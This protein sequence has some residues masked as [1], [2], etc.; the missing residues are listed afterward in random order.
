MPILKSYESHSSGSQLLDETSFQ[1]AS[2]SANRGRLTGR[3]HTHHDGGSHVSTE[4]I[5]CAA[6]ADMTG[7]L[8]FT[9]TATA[10][11]G[12]IVSTSRNL[13]TLTGRVWRQTNAQ[14]VA[15]VYTY[16]GLG[17]MVKRTIAPGTAYV[18]MLTLDPVITGASSEAFQVTSTDVNGNKIRKGMDGTGRLLY[19]APNDIDNAI[20][21]P[22]SSLYQTS[23]R[24]YDALGR[25]ATL[26]SRDWLLE[27]SEQYSRTGTLGYDDWGQP[28][29]MDYDDGSWRSSVHDP[30]ALS[31]TATMGGTNKSGSVTSGLTVTTHDVSGKPVRVAR[32]AKNADP[33]SATPYS[34]HTLSYDGLHRLRSQTDALTHT[35]TYEYDAW[36]RLVSSTLADLTV[37]TR[38][39]RADSASADIVEITVT[40]TKLGLAKTSMGTRAFDGLGR[41]SAAHIGGRAWQYDYARPDRSTQLM[42]PHPTQITAP[43]GTV[44]QYDY[45]PELGNKVKQVRGYA[46]A[47]A[48]LARNPSITQTFGYDVSTGQMTSA[49]EGAASGKYETYNSG[50]LKT[51]TL[52]RDGKT[53]TM[54]YQ[55]YSLR[56]KLHQY[57]HVDSAVRLLKRDTGGRV[58]EVGD[59]AMKVSLNYDPAGRLTSWTAQDLKGGTAALTTTLQFDD[60]GREIVRSIATANDP[61]GKPS[62]KITQVWDVCDKLTSSIIQRPGSTYRTSMYEYDG[63]NRLTVWRAQGTGQQD[64]YGNTLNMQTFTLDPLNNIT[65]VVSTWR[66][67][68]NTGTFNYTDASDPCRLTSFTN[69]QAPYPGAG[70]AA[71]TLGYDAA[72]RIT[73]DGMGQQFLAY[74]TL[75]RLTQAKSTLT[76]HG[77]SYAYDAHN[78]TCRQTVDGQGEPTY[79]YYQAN[80]LV[81]LVQGSQSS[82]ML[83]SPAGCTSQYV[84]Q[85]DAVWLTGSDSQDSALAANQGGSV[86]TYAYSAYGEAPPASGGSTLLGY[87]GQ[88]R[89]PVLPGYQLGNGYRTYLP[90]LMRFAQ[91][92]S[93][94]YSPFGKGG[95]NAYA[96]CGG[97]PLNHSDPGG[98][99]DWSNIVAGLIAIV[100]GALAVAAAPLTG[101]ASIAAYV[102]TVAGMVAIVAGETA[103]GTSIAGQLTTGKTSNKLEEVSEYSSY[104]G[105]VAGLA[106]GVADVAGLVVATAAEVSTETIETTQLAAQRAL[107]P[108]LDRPPVPSFQEAL[109]A[110]RPTTDTFPLPDTEFFDEPPPNDLVLPNRPPVYAENAGVSEGTGIGRSFLSR[111]GLD[112]PSF[113]Q[114]WGAERGITGSKVDFGVVPF[115]D[116]QPPPGYNYLDNNVWPHGDTGSVGGVSERLYFFLA[117]TAET[118]V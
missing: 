113:Q 93:P 33:S 23:S 6:D 61:A 84:G 25:L 107:T 30:I 37:V 26:T 52:G 81:N 3:T 62:W 47:S 87:T 13:S 90:G 79:F 58:I 35:T 72:G 114:V 43:D 24:T 75:G 11:D 29:R 65:Q 20:D 94:G 109:T 77:G 21:Q 59:E 96:Y 27:T 100:G 4:A 49:V 38:R 89:D 85:G 50:R 99:F 18:N 104:V 56:G 42:D 8:L 63:R 82:R 7:T 102:A 66:N 48:V 91:P 69:S 41:V 118:S 9:R 64:R 54:D 86:E 117:D 115:S 53:R 71:V 68:S 105:M 36:N 95:I 108:L 57:Q 98:H 14:G 34:V 1:Y 80:A 60:Y 76:G 5:T 97:D 110:A 28:A 45:V 116:E 101:G 46:D 44:R 106:G 12:L 73:D 39:Y 51:Q 103:I 83:R 19:V 31:T 10:S 32:Y 74:D 112:R 111:I 67:G 88:Y 70:G 16:D 92:D 22:D 17:R 15:T 2:D 55:K 78:R 40:N